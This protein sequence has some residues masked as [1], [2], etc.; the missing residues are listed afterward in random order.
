MHHL[1]TIS[2]AGKTFSLAAFSLAA[3]LTF[4]CSSD[5]AEVEKA[6]RAAETAAKKA[7]RDIP[8]QIN[9]TRPFLYPE[10]I[11]F[12]RRNDRFLVSSVSTGTIG[13]VAYDGTYAP[14]IQDLA[15]TATVGLTIDE[16][17]RRVLVAVSNPAL[18]NVAS[19]GIY[20]LNT[21]ER[22]EL[23]NLLEAGGGAANFANDVALDPQGNAY[24][25]N[26]FSPIIYKVDRD[27]NASVFFQNNQFATAPG[28]FGFNG[29]A[30]HNSGFLIVA[31]SKENALYKIPLRDPSAFRKIEL[32]APL[33]SPDG[34]LL[35]QDGKQL[36]VVNNAGGSEAGR[37]LSFVSDDKW[38]TGQLADSF[39]T[40]PVFPTTATSDGKNVYVLYAY[41]NRLFNPA[42]PPQNTFTIQRVPFA[43]NRPF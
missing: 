41:L 24:V 36:V 6:G 37:V 22:I 40:G 33:Q 21:G 15:L 39:A 14:F 30:Y 5:V 32:D 38:E 16:A 35:S 8:D 34:L 3:A 27:G 43:D 28:E 26:S 25:T 13:A 2:R 18:G 9:F 19:L 23:V 1:T 10:G 4:S 17:R 11:A 29:I 7:A 42:L 31:F 20:D 12:D